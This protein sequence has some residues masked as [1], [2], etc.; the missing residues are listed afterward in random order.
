MI[1]EGF[2]DVTDEP[3]A[4]CDGALPGRIR[5]RG[6][7]HGAVTDLLDLE[8]IARQVFE[9]YSKAGVPA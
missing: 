5:A 4:V 6:I 9:E 3:L 7:L 8:T 1:T 2:L